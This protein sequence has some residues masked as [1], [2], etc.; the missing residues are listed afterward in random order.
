MT[1]ARTAAVVLAA[2]LSGCVT[3]PIQLDGHQMGGSTTATAAPQKRL[4]R[5][6]ALPR[7]AI[8]PIED[9]RSGDSAGYVAGRTV[10]VKAPGAWLDGQLAAMSSAAFEVVS[11][12]ELDPAPALVVHPRVLKAYMSAMSTS[13]TAV[14]VLEVETVAP[15][16]Q[17]TTHQYRGQYVSVN[18][19]SGE[20]EV[21]EALRS[22]ALSCLD[23]LRVDLEA[24]LLKS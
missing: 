18:W 19:A 1:R 20:D 23:Q 8:A 14:V 12:G 16:G 4:A 15:D 6:A 2:S 21:K 3:T 17:A 5:R 24:Q 22:A 13:K 11:E 9:R 7:V 10:T